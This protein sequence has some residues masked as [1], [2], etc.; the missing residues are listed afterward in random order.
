MA[1]QTIP[2][3]KCLTT[4]LI[5]SLLIQ[6]SVVGIAE[7]KSSGVDSDE[8]G[9]DDELDDCPFI[10]GNST[11][12]PNVGC[13]D[14]DDDGYS[15]IDD[16]HPD[17]PRQHVDSD[18]DGYGDNSS[19]PNGDAFINDSSQWRD[20]DGDGY[21]DNQTGN[22]SDAF[23]DEP[24]QWND[25]DGDGYGDNEEGINPDDC[26]STAGNSTHDRLGCHDSDG[27]RWS[28][29]N[30]AFSDDWSQWNDT[31]GDGFGDN[32]ANP[33]WNT[34]RLLH[35]PGEFVPGANL[36]DQSP[37]D[38]DDDRFEDA[39][40]ELSITPFDDCPDIPGTSIS[41]RFGCSDVDNDGFSNEGD[42]FPTESTQ[43]NDTDG[44]GYGDNQEGA[45]PDGCPTIEGGSSH[46]RLGCLDND[47]D[48]W[49]DPSDPQT[50]Y[51]WNESQG[52]DLFPADRTRWNRSHLIVETIG[53]VVSD[54]GEGGVVF[55]M[56]MG[57][58]ITMVVAFFFGYVIWRA[59]DDYDDESDEIDVHDS[60][61]EPEHAPVEESPEEL[62]DG[63]EGG[64]LD[65]GHEVLDSVEE[66][67]QILDKTTEPSTDKE[68]ADKREK[69]ENA[70]DSLPV[71]SEPLRDDP[72]D[73]HD[74]A[75]EPLLENEETEEVTDSDGEDAAGDENVIRCSKDCRCEM[76]EVPLELEQ[77]AL[78][79]PEVAEEKEVY[80]NHVEKVWRIEDI[81]LEL[82]EVNEELEY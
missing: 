61:I 24:T 9:I 80:W 65:Q 41:D 75:D 36:P 56:G 3:P 62:D 81:L 74:E 51:P 45:Q 10:A 32:W 57:S 54:S 82:K 6:S 71:E 68:D 29:E 11:Q 70:F 8:D 39:G 50:D 2:R 64:A 7:E 17:D 35:W 18:G 21:G 33:I 27:D 22:L 77:L 26:P 30:D 73:E 72:P 59:R 38:Y 40:L 69:L 34:S 58:L 19:A 79:A 14:R 5:L 49:S 60:P 28:D 42:A 31:D 47:G 23:I 4:L 55:G 76:Q 78:L 15:D 52:A 43:W 16:S 63:D 46:D 53:T 25:Q 37:L 44:D 12:P 48:G 13:P 20:S 66:A 1:A 67:T